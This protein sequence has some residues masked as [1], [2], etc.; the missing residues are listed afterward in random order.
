L[1]DQLFVLDGVIL[2]RDRVVIPPSLRSEV[3]QSYITDQGTRILIP[4]SLRPEVLQSL[5]AAHQGVS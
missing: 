5:H 4:S 1:R 3:T 2:M